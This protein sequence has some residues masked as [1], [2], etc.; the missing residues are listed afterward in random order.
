MKDV[1]YYVRVEGDKSAKG[2]GEFEVYQ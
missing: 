1:G 2:K